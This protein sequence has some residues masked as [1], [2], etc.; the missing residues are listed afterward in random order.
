VKGLVRLAALS[1]AI[2]VMA[3]AFGAHATS[4]KPAEWLRTGAEYQMI[5][6]V[7]ALVAARSGGHL[8]AALL[9]GGSILFAATL[10]AIAVGA[11]HWL[12]AVTPLGGIGMIAGWLSLAGKTRRGAG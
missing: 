11:P 12:G 9:L 4:G 7:A 1:G 8:A 6:A 5:H 2:A 10:Y 3:G